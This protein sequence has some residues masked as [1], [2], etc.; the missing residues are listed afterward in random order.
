VIVPGIQRPSD[1]GSFGDPLEP[2]RKCGPSKGKASVYMASLLSRA[3][4][5][6]HETACELAIA[7]Y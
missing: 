6:Q 4:C 5:K 7:G 3:T 1:D 2:V